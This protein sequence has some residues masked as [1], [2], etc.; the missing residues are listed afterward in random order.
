MTI[1]YLN[2]TN[3]LTSPGKISD[4]CSQT[5]IFRYSSVTQPMQLQPFALLVVSLMV[6]FL[7]PI[8]PNLLE[9]TRNNS[10]KSRRDVTATEK[11]QFS[12][13]ENKFG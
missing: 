9:C 10:L 1:C 5:N 6:V 4:E 7:L 13:P 12:F 11:K 3:V 2:S 8:D